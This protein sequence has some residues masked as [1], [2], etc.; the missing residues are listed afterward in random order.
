MQ[1]VADGDLSRKVD[2]QLNNEF[3]SIAESTNNMI[4]GLKQKQFLQKSID[5]LVSEDVSEIIINSIRDG[6]FKPERKKMCILFTDIRGF[7]EQCATSEPEEFVSRLNNHFGAV[8]SVVKRH[9]GYVNKFIGDALMAC[10][11]GPSASENGLK[12]ADDLAA[13]MDERK[14][15]D[16]GIGIAYGDVMSGLIGSEDRLEYTVIGPAVNLA[17]RLEAMT[18]DLECRIVVC[19]ETVSDHLENHGFETIVRPVKGFSEEMTV[20]YK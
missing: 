2:V 14:D 3:G 10:F 11:D 7:T 20:Y 17:A 15:F 13:L 6:N 9:D 16:I 12:V 18:R 5:K 8:V 4:D 19:G 1:L